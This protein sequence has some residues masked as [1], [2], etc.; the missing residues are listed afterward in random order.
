MYLITAYFDD[1]TNRMLQAYID[2][3]AQATGNNFMTDNHV[4]PHLTLSA[5]EAREAKTLATGFDLLEGKIKATPIRIVTVGQLLPYVMYVAPVLDRSLLELQES[6]SNAFKTIP[7]TMISKYYQPYSWFPHITL[8]K[9]LQKDQMQAAF[10]IMQEKFQ[11]I[12]GV[13]TKVDL[14]KVNPHEDLAMYYLK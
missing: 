13:I 6:V 12:K 7:E 2:R 3:I 10:C 14:A 8:A 9:K 1:N 4:P 5:I 11:P